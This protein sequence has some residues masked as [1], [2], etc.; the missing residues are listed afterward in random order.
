MKGY[1]E[2]GELRIDFESLWDGLDPVEKERLLSEVA[3]EELMESIAWAVINDEVIMD[4][5]SYTNH[6]RTMI[7]KHYGTMEKNYVKSLLQ[8]IEQMRLKVARM[9]ELNEVLR[10]EIG[11]NRVLELIEDGKY[12]HEGKAPMPSDEDALKVMQG[13]SLN[14]A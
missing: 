11:F 4:S 10:K 7:L 8:Q 12:P 14:P 5:F 13:A 2:N 1:I 3:W 9:E 6:I